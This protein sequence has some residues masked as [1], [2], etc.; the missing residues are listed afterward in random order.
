MN[1]GNSHSMGGNFHPQNHPVGFPVP[2]NG[3]EHSNLQMNQNFSSFPPVPPPHI[4]DQ[5]ERILNDSNSTSVY[6]KNS[7]DWV[8]ENIAFSP[9][10]CQRIARKMDES[11]F[12]SGKKLS[13]LFLLNDVLHFSLRMRNEP[14]NLDL[15]AACLLPFLPRILCVIYHSDPMEENSKQVLKII[16]LWK[17]RNIYGDSIIL[18]L[19]S[20]AKN[21]NTLN[22]HPVYNQI[23]PPLP[24][25]MHNNNPPVPIGGFQP[26]QNFQQNFPHIPPHPSLSFVPPPHNQHQN[27]PNQPPNPHNIPNYQNNNLPQIHNNNLNNPMGFQPPPHNFQHQN[28]PHQ[29]PPLPYAAPPPLPHSQHPNFQGPPPNFGQ[30]PLPPFVNAPHFNAQLPPQ[31]PPHVPLQKIPPSVPN[32]IPPPPQF[33]FEQIYD[34]LKANKERAPYTPIPTSQILPVAVHPLDQKFD[35]KVTGKLIELTLKINQENLRLEQ[36]F[37]R[38]RSRSRSRSRSPSRSPPRKTRGRSRSRSR[39]P[40]PRRS[41]SSR[42]RPRTSSLT[43]KIDFDATSGTR[44]DGSAAFNSGE[45]LGLGAGNSN[46]EDIFSSYRQARSSKYHHKMEDIQKIRESGLPGQMGSRCFNCSQIGHIA[47]NCP[48]K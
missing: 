39:S 16:G 21:A 29:P 34:H 17:S 19:E 12:P 41:S 5:M 22:N 8:M 26:P 44:S 35:A 1:Q 4:F 40:S 32:S 33:H 47:K 20:D 15:F 9:L 11:N 13:L 23:P 43:N 14:Q 27:Y 28:F 37:P 48:T 18:N 24:P 45:R 30:G 3:P 31:I 46:E 2:L 10:I 38:E 42:G 6:I 36:M 7:K 25:Q